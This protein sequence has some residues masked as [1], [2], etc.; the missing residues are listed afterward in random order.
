[1]HQMA[2]F[3]LVACGI[4]CSLTDGGRIFAGKEHRRGPERAAVQGGAEPGGRSDRLRRRADEAGASGGRR[5]MVW[6]EKG[7]GRTPVVILYRVLA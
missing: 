4:P 5:G 3:S 1:L 7:E 2:V 6:K